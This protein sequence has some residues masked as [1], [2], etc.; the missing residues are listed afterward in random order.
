MQQRV[1]TYPGFG[2]TF[3]SPA[4]VAEISDS[5]PL[6][7]LQPGGW[8]DC[9]GWGGEAGEFGGGLGGDEEAVEAGEAGEGWEGGAGG[10]GGCQISSSLSN[11]SVGGEE[12]SLM[13]SRLGPAAP[14]DPRAHI[15]KTPGGGSK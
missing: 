11:T 13:A 6:E 9:G 2:G 15:T 7:L 12:S 14:P 3:N 8:G 5:S 10:Q 4:K 1:G